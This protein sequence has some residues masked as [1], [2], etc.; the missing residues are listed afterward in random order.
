MAMLVRL[1][2]KDAFRVGVELWGKDYW[3]GSHRTEV[4]ELRAMLAAVGWKLGRQVKCTDWCKV[5]QGALVAVQWKRKVERW[6]WVVS[7]QDDE[8][9]FVYDPRAMV[10]TNRRRDFQSVPV[11]WYHRVRP[12]SPQTK[13]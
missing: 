10:K 4:G 8:G 13:K 12:I 3:K 6:H 1:S 5:P 7:D 2:F 9:P 11:A